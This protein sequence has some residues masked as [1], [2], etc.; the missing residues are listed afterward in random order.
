MFIWEVSKGNSP[1]LELT[2]LRHTQPRPPW[3]SDCTP[4]KSRVREENL[5]RATPWSAARS[6]ALPLA[7]MCAARPE[8]KE[9]SP[10]VFVHWAEDNQDFPHVIRVVPLNRRSHPPK[11]RFRVFIPAEELWSKLSTPEPIRILGGERGWATASSVWSFSPR[12][13]C[14]TGSSPV[15]HTN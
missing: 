12:T 5:S 11:L 1:I 3:I 8:K 13:S 2:V 6:A 4:R 7:S 10:H 14:Q 15:V 9:T